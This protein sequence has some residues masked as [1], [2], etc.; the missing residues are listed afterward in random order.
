EALFQGG[1]RRGENQGERRLAGLIHVDVF[2][3]VELGEGSGKIRVF[4]VLERLE[5]S[6]AREGHRRLRFGRADDDRSQ[7]CSG[8]LG[9]AKH[10]SNR[11]ARKGINRQVAKSAKVSLVLCGCDLSAFAVSKGDDIARGSARL[12]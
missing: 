6:F 2:D 5:R 9:T 10:P 12:L 7:I 3:Q 11:I 8:T 1:A 4:D